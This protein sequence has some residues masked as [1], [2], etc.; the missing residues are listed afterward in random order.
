MS[1]TEQVISA[2]YEV[3]DQLKKAEANHQ[4]AVGTIVLANEYSPC[5]ISEHG[6]PNYPT[7]GMAIVIR[8][9]ITP[10]LVQRAEHIQH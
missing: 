6:H 5:E 10:D 2:L 9:R 1:S 4:A 3:I 7:G 8:I